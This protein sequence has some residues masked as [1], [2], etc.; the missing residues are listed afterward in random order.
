MEEFERILKET[1][2]NVKTVVGCNDVI[3]KP[4][5]NGDGT[6]ILPVSKISYGFVAGGGGAVKPAQKDGS[7]FAS[8]SGGGMTVTPVGFLICGREKKFVTVDK[9]EDGNKWLNLF[10]SICDTLKG[11]K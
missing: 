1:V 7:P 9:T 2:E 10:E 5:V 3:G 6:I 11:D 4:I 8:A